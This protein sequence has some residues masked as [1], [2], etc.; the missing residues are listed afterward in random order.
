[1]HTGQR[2]RKVKR[3]RERG[4]ERGRGRDKER[5][6]ERERERKREG[7][8]HASGKCGRALSVPLSVSQSACVIIIYTTRK[9]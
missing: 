9:D 8:L 2:E 4:K 3:E 1:V 7:E 5:E 6:R